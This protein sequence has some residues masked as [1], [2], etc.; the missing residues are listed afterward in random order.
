MILE[1]ERLGVKT[2]KEDFLYTVNPRISGPRSSGVS[3]YL[4]TKLNLVHPGAIRNAV[5]ACAVLTGSAV[6][7]DRAERWQSLHLLQFHHLPE[8]REEKEG[9]VYRHQ[10][11]YFGVPL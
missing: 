10:A 1:E 4:D 6:S 5:C 11:G 8:Y 3:D 7:S 2:N 9:F